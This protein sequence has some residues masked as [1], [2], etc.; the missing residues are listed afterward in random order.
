MSD[1]DKDKKVE[2]EE[3][4]KDDLS[5]IS[6]SSSKTITNFLAA[7]FVLVIALSFGG[8]LLYK[9]FVKGNSEDNQA[10]S[11]IGTK[12]D[13]SALTFKEAIELDKK[14]TVEEVK[15][16]EK[17]EDIESNP[18][19][20]NNTSNDLKVYKSDSSAIIPL[21]SDS[22][23]SL[24]EI[25][26]D[27]TRTIVSPTGDILRIDKN[28]NIIEKESGNEIAYNEHDNNIMGQVFSP[29]IAKKSKY[30]PNLLLS[31][32]TYIGCSLNTRVVS[33]IAG[34]ISCTISQNVYSS[35]GNVLL[36][37]RGSI[38]TGYFNSGQLKNGMNRIFV[39]WQEIKTPKNI[40][41]PVYSGASDELGG[42]GMVGEVDNHYLERFGA[43]ILLSVIDDAFNVLLNGGT[44]TRDNKNTDYTESTRE[45]TK[46]MASIALEKF[47]NIE[48]TLYK[49][50][51][52]LVGIY[53]NKDID[54][55]KVYSLKRIVK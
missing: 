40:I 42:S 39:T 38:V 46:E 37:E 30:N 34:G 6:N 5:Q 43:S 11:E 12:V 53:V 48:P 2:T 13:K 54:F 28:G 15:E 51:G 3:E 17:V 10:L 35:N 22:S 1:K 18:F 4:V 36:I 47:I 44:G 21:N 19:V 7:T 33:T 49:N 52:D 16:E 32:G 23:N 45:T 55:S 26:S 50:Q 27:G 20:V 31:K 24:G 41:I 9:N 29:Q 25:N 8:Y 14:P